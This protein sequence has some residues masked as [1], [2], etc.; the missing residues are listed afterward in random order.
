MNFLKISRMK[1]KP[2]K[3]LATS[4]GLLLYDV[5][6]LLAKSKKTIFFSEPQEVEYFRKGF[7]KTLHPV[8]STPLSHIPFPTPSSYNSKAAPVWLDFPPRTSA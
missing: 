4:F 3:L 7:K 8:G 6:V 5:Y 2:W 1:S